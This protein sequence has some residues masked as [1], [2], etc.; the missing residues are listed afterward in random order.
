MSRHFKQRARQ[1]LGTKQGN[2]LIA[3]LA[4]MLQRG[5]TPPDGCF[6]VQGYGTAV[7]E[8]GVF[9]TFLGPDMVAYT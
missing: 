2:K 9:K 7:V 4:Y 8:G 3:L 6:S 5:N 1:R